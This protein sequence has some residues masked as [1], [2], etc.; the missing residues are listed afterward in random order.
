[1]LFVYSSRHIRI[2]TR[3]TQLTNQSL[4]QIYNVHSQNAKRECPEGRKGQPQFDYSVLP[5]PVLFG[6]L[7]S[8]IT[9]DN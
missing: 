4:P 2:N 6:H 7:L 5:S 9:L 3:S 8:L 1:M